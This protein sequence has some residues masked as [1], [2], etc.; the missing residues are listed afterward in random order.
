MLGARQNKNAKLEKKAR[1]KIIADPDFFLLRLLLLMC[2][3]IFKL[4]DDAV[5]WMRKRR[6]VGEEEEEEEVVV[7]GRRE[8]LLAHSSYNLVASF[9]L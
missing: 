9:L 3:C 7:V 1:S 6:W 4:V 5:G 2:V 8:S